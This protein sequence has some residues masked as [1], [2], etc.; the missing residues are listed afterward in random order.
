MKRIFAIGAALVVVTAIGCT[1]SNNT[2]ADGGTGLVVAPQNVD[3]TKVENCY[4]L[5]CWDDPAC[6]EVQS[7]GNCPIGMVT[8]L[9]KEAGADGGVACRACTEDDCDGLA[10]YCCG[11]DVCKNHVECGMF[12]CKDIEAS[13]NGITS[14]TCGFHDLD[15]DDAWGDCDEAPSDPCCYCKVAVG[16]TDSKCGFGQ[17]VKNGACATCTAGDCLHPPCMGLNGCAT[18]CPL[19]DAGGKQYFDGVRCRSCDSSSS[20]DLIPACNPNGPPDS[21]L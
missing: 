4:H 5:A 17:F 1:T 2:T 12:V 21:G 3:C 9:T 6:G 18:N 15:G 11:A 13:C 8:D 10:G 14:E 20:V 7:P 19:D 16:C